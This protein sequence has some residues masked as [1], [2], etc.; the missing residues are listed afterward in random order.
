MTTIEESIEKWVEENP[1]TEKRELFS[2]EGYKVVIVPE[3]YFGAQPRNFVDD[4]NTNDNNDSYCMVSSDVDW[5]CTR[6]EG[7]P[8]PHVAGYNTNTILQVW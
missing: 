7:H 8:G 1:L 3:D 6:K 4:A 5:A 2:G